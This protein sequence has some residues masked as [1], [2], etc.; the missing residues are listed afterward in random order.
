MKQE[1]QPIE[2]APKDRT[3]ILV[4]T[5]HGD[6][7][8]TEW[9]IIENSHYEEAGNDLYRKVIDETTEF[10]NSNKPTHWMPLPEPPKIEEATHEKSAPA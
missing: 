4:F 7:E 3:K 8:L 10:W 9:C 6:I 1:W 5:V 2:T